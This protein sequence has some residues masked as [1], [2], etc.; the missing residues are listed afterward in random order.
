MNLKQ[1]AVELGVHYQ[2]AY[3]WVRSGELPAVRIGTRYEVSPDAVEQFI[4]NRRSM[5]HTADVV[6]SDRRRATDVHSEDLLEELEAM[7]ADPIVAIPAIEGFAARGAV[8]VLGDACIIRISARDGTFLGVV[9][10][11]AR[12]EF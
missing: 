4:A 7:A 6:T 9:G 12:I 1:A 10:A 11:S 8:S 5:V 3:K 2:T